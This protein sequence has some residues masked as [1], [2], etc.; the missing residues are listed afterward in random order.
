V[1]SW[2]VNAQFTSSGGHTGGWNSFSGD[3]SNYQGTYYLDVSINPST[4]AFGIP[5]AFYF[6]ILTTDGATA[7]AVNL[8]TS[9]TVS[10][11]DPT[12]FLSVTLPDKGNVT[13]ES[14]GVSVTFD[15]GL[16]SPN[17]LPSVPEP[18]SLVLACIGATGLIGYGWRRRK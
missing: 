2:S 15:S 11:F 10:S 13:P 14:L 7:R 4:G 5:G 8:S 3:A 1:N 12:Q 17:L 9:E 16:I 6:D 18:S